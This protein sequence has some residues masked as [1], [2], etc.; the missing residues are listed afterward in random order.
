MF[1]NIL[2]HA[3][4]SDA[5]INNNN[6]SKFQPDYAARQPIPAAVLVMGHT[7]KNRYIV[8]LVNNV[9]SG[10]VFG[11][12]ELHLHHAISQ[13]R[14]Y[15]HLGGCRRRQSRSWQHPRNQ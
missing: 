2:Q 15:H 6:T 11:R 9:I 8:E 7:I 10:I 14:H 3:R 12:I 1:T 5:I 4:P 13:Q